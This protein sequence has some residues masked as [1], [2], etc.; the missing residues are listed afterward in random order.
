M[1]N[2]NLIRMGMQVTRW[3]TQ[4]RVKEESVGH[5]TAN[6]IAILLAV[7]PNC[8]KEVIV[9]AVY[10]DVAEFV[11]GDCPATVKHY[12]AKV[13]KALDWL[14]D[15]FREQSGITA[16]LLTNSEKNLLHYCDRLESLLS[17]V[18]DMNK[19][20][21]YAE[22]IVNNAVEM[23]DGMNVTEEVRAAGKA[24]YKQVKENQQ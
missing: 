18:E 3:H 22:M 19:G 12:D 10:H 9:E 24:M 6:F 5:H 16:D 15:N 2:I 7:D 8:R 17:A 21:K 1:I 13:G 23:L 4:P 11:T 14:E 20:N